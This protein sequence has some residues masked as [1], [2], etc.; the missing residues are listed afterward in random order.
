MK[1]SN[2]V[3]RKHSVY[4]EKFK[5]G[6]LYFAAKMRWPESPG[7]SLAWAHSQIN[8][9][10]L[11]DKYI[12]F[13]GITDRF[14]L[15]KGLSCREAKLIKS[16]LIRHSILCGDTCLNII[17]ETNVE[18]TLEKSVY[19]QDYCNCEHERAMELILIFNSLKK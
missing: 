15:I 5:D 9:R 19:I 8:G 14:Q 12:E 11:V 17:R 18:L 1:S 13:Q 3:V 6:T 7:K 10:P 4:L 2:Q 16:N